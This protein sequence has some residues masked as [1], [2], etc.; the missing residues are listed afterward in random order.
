M[1]VSFN[2]V[3]GRPTLPPSKDK[4]VQKRREAQRVPESEKKGKC[5]RKPLPPSD[6]PK[7]Q[8][9][10]EKARAAAEK[11][12]EGVKQVK[13][14]GMINQ[15]LK[16]KI[17]RKRLEDAKPSPST[18]IKPTATKTP[19][20][21][22]N[23]IANFLK[24]KL[25]LNK[26][27]LQNR[28][29]RYNIVSKA[30]Q[31]LK[32]DDCLEA[33]GSGFTIRNI[34][35]LEKQI[36]SKSKFGSIYLTSLRNTL[37]SFPI[38]SKV[39]KEARENLFETDMMKTIT[40][41][42]ILKGHSKHFAIIYNSTLCTKSKVGLTRRLVNYNELCNGD[43]KT[44]IEDRN[45]LANEELMFNIFLQVYISIGTFHNTM[46]YYH[47][48][49]HYGNFLHQAN[50][51][52]GYYHYKSGNTDFYL[53]S[54]PYNM[55]IY[56]FGFAMKIKANDNNETIK[57]YQNIYDDYARIL[58][59]FYSKNFGWGIYRDLPPKDFD[60][61]VAKIY[62]GSNDIF[63]ASL[64]EARNGAPE[65]IENFKQ[66]FFVKILELFKTLAPAGLILDNRPP[67]VINT[68]PFII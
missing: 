55:T 16:M 1:V 45:L 59:A 5:G 17:A 11:K 40:E 61:K 3:C 6:D 35:N 48:D 15:A 13:A 10:R 47:R 62:R 31:E 49:A 46:N 51:E 60:I 28:I 27:S 29:N 8:A 24:N 18:S 64:R 36:G 30:L 7:V 68:Q 20:D 34:V 9:R 26:Y 4:D 19:F 53:K 54:C 21:N 42:I 66:T 57:M 32:P 12:R 65:P 41:Y 39:M 38:A 43:L 22:A 37:G 52:T 33:K 63:S 25:I 2:P 58:N 50:N 23:I 56:D 44:L 67:N 14:S